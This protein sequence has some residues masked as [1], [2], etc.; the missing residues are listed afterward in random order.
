MARLAGPKD[1]PPSKAGVSIGDLVSGLYCVQGILAALYERERTGR[2]KRVD[3]AMLDGLVSLLT[4]QA[5]AWLVGNKP[6][7]RIGNQHPSIC[8]FETLRTQDG[9]LAVCCGN[10]KQWAR[11]AKALGLEALLADPR[12]ET[13]SLRVE[14]RPAL[15]PMLEEVLTSAPGHVWLERLNAA[16]VPCAPIQSVPEAL[17][18]PQLEARGIIRTVEHPTAGPMKAVATPIRLDGQTAFDPRPAPT[19]GQHTA[20]ILDELGLTPS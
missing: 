19:P 8:P 20:E 1:A 18:H 12:F 4:Y 2:G 17:R 3:I 9:H 10:D 15:I 11:L 5:A 14:H 16:D 6:P 13:N 7:G